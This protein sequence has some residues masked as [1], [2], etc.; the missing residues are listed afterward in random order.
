MTR[1]V[2]GKKTKEEKATKLNKKD[3][4]RKKERECD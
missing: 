1:K 3:K 4:G 2:V